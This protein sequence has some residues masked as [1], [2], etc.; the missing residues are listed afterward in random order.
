MS[1]TPMTQADGSDQ[2]WA[3]IDDQRTRT[4]DLLGTLTAAEWREPSLC[5][6]W[7]VRDVAALLTLQQQTVGSTLAFV[8]R[9]PSALSADLNRTINRS[10]QIVAAELSTDEIIRRIRAMV[11]SRRHNSFV[12][13]LEALTDALVHSQ[14]IAIPLGRPLEMNPRAAVAAATRNWDTR[15]SWL[16]RV[17]RRVPFDGLRLRATDADWT[18]GDGP[19]VSGPI[20][21]LLLLLTGRPAR[22]AD[23]TG[24]GAALVRARL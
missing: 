22:V 9:H 19:E 12:T 7:T 6:G 10:A 1:T 2:L 15:A 16:A 11:G 3:A 14:D 13:P 17:F 8:V 4:A 18:V 5:D 23:L 20:A 24:D 21:A